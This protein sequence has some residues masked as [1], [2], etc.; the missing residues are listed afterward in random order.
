MG[1]NAIGK[2][3]ASAMDCY[4]QQQVQQAQLRS[5]VVFMEDPLFWAKGVFIE[6]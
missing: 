1:I 2:L 3:K 4:L 6:F 5:A